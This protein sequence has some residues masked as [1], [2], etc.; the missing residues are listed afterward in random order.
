MTDQEAARA[1][2]F[3]L[4]EYYH[5]AATTTQ[6]VSDAYLAGIEHERARVLDLFRTGC[7]TAPEARA[8]I[9]QVKE[10]I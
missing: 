8:A 7:W 9:C 2:A 5:A 10:K 1:Y 4:S 6:V 3:S